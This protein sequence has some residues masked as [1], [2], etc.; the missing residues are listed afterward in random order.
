MTKQP[1]EDVGNVTNNIDLIAAI[2]NIEVEEFRRSAILTLDTS[3]TI[4]TE[5]VSR[6]GKKFGDLP[7]QNI[8]RAYFTGII[9][10]KDKNS[11]FKIR[12]ESNNYETTAAALADLLVCAK[13]KVERACELK[14]RFQKGREWVVRRNVVC[15][16]FFLLATPRPRSAGFT[17]PP[18][19]RPRPTTPAMSRACRFDVLSG[20][21]LLSTSCKY[22]IK[23]LSFD[24]LCRQLGLLPT[25]NGRA[26]LAQAVA[27]V[28]NYLKQILLHKRQLCG[29]F[30]S[31]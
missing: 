20:R 6:K 27:G 23:A 11:E 29:E 3:M 28:L 9:K 17:T 4:A 25:A 1:R 18:P 21:S 26:A 5:N 7:W 14:G 16:R 2:K 30:S 12:I 15:G 13:T 8:L 10:A 22:T 19:R 24:T 31:T